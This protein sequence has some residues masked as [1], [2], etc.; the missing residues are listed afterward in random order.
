MT[1]RQ[2]KF[3][4]FFIS[5]LTYTF[6][7][8]FFLFYFNYSNAQKILEKINSPVIFQGD[9]RTAYRD[10][11]YCSIMIAFIY[12]LHWLKMKMKYFP[13]LHAVTQVT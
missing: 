2:K 8:F 10:L 5:R 9:E 11:R 13:I 3:G 6:T 4:E 1:N 7:Y 12:S